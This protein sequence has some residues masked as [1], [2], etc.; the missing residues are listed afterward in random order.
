[1]S[2]LV[3]GWL[4]MADEPVLT[5]VRKSATIKYNGTNSA[6]I[7]G[8][9]QGIYATQQWTI[10]SE[11]GTGVDRVLTLGCKF[12]N[13]TAYTPFP[14][15]VGYYIVGDLAAQGTWDIVSPAMG[16]KK[17]YVMP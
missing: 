12:D 13:D 10:L 4:S 1:M 14:M 7:L 11:L 3:R 17:Y 16:A 5:V 8:G 2:L 9:L 6:Q 15:P